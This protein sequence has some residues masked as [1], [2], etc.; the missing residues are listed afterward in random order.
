[1]QQKLAIAAFSFIIGLPLVL[2]VLGM[3]GD[4]ID[5]RA[6]KPLAAPSMQTLRNASW[7]AQFN[8]WLIDHTPLR[9]QAVR[10]AAWL[11][12]H[13]FGN[14]GNKQVSV[15]KDEWLFLNNSLDHPCVAPDEIKRR[16]LRLAE[17]AKAYAEQH[18]T[19]IVWVIAPNKE[20]IYPER[21]SALQTVRASC[22]TANRTA[23]REALADPALSPYIT[24]LWN[25]L[26]ARKSE[27][28]F[29]RTDS[30]WNFRGAAYAMEAMMAALW[31]Q[32]ST[33]GAFHPME[34]IAYKGDLG[35]ML[36]FADMRED[37]VIWRGK[38]EGIRGGETKDSLCITQG[39]PRLRSYRHQGSAPLV[40]GKTVILRD[41]FFDAPL[42]L[43]P[44]LFAQVDIGHIDHTPPADWPA[45]AACADTLVIESVERNV[46]GRAEAFAK[47][48]QG[49]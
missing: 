24:G 48:L 10:S 17:V 37:E 3:R 21:L 15:G 1:M 47:T 46:L 6:A 39:T 14:S 8:A 32:V 40:Q 12:W 30:H 41:S 16:F 42:H 4:N 45:I 43:M 2:F 22:A 5:N 44:P 28:I 7:F 11:D 33:Q 25:A 49:H 34:T 19:R 18:H 20:S 29:R 38:R 36:G 13:L 26:E 9:P 27:S 31:P 35:K 23:M